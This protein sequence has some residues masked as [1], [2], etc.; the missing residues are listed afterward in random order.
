MRACSWRVPGL[1]SSSGCS[2]S[3]WVSWTAKPWNYDDVPG[4]ASGAWT[5]D[6]PAD[7]WSRTNLCAPSATYTYIGDG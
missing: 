2:A 1:A 5:N 6:S 7:I 3:A 4:G